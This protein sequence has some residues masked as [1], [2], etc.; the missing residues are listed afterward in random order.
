MREGLLIVLSPV[1]LTLLSMYSYRVMEDNYST[2]GDFF[3]FL[4]LIGTVIFGALAFF[5]VI[6]NIVVFVSYSI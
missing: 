2:S 3:E 5:A 4:G 6:L 1:I